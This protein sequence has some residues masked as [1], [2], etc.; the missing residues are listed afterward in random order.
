LI[1]GDEAKPPETK[2][3]FLDRDDAD[4]GA[5]GRGGGVRLQGAP[6]WT[7]YGMRVRSLMQ[8]I[9]AISKSS[10]HGAAH[11][12]IDG[13]VQGF[14]ARLTYVIACSEGAAY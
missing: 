10:A 13:S 12:A 11:R 6:G 4:G 7:G 5:G 2:A 1:S 8:R 3:K 14:L 9:A